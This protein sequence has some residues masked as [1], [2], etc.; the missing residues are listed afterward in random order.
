M[1]VLSQKTNCLVASNRSVQASAGFPNLYQSAVTNLAPGQVGTVDFDP[2][3]LVE[4]DLK[5]MFEE[6]HDELDLELLHD[7]ELG[8]M[9]KYYFDGAG[10]AVRPVIAMCVGHALNH[11]MGTG[12]ENVKNQRK[13]AIISEMIH[14]AWNL[15]NHMAHGVRKPLW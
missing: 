11:H 13:V 15:S 10:K 3:T 9:S 6:I 8:E 14:T 1:C 7:S 12:Y 5:T 2:F 4:G